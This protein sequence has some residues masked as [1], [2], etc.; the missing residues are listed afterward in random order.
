MITSNENC[1]CVCVVVVVNSLFVCLIT[2]DGQAVL[3]AVPIVC[4]WSRLLSYLHTASQVP[5]LLLFIIV[6]LI[7]AV[8]INDY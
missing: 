8:Q 3:S 7:R 6:V 5:M 2:G 4:C 1:V